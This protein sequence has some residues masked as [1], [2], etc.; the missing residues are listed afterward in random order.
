MSYQDF[1]ATLIDEVVTPARIETAVNEVAGDRVEVGPLGV[2]PGDAASVVAKGTIAAASAR[3]TTPERDGTRR[4]VV[5]I[6]VELRLSVK[7]AGTLH[8]FEATVVV[9]L[10][11]AVRTA[12]RPLSLVIDIAPPDRSDMDVE[13]R[14]S[15]MVGRVLGRL[16]N[17]DDKIRR[18]VIGF[19]RA[20]LDAA[21]ARAATVINIGDTVESL[22]RS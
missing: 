4:F 16:G 14:A 18:E 21:D 13:V 9:H 6:P 11:L 10:L 3:S 2:G 19:I 20:R 15:G 17:V 8:R 5:D 22:W 1:G 7:V 12:A